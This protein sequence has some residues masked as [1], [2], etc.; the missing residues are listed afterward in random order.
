MVALAAEL[1][2]DFETPGCMNL[3]SKDCGFRGGGF[4]FWWVDPSGGW[5][6]GRLRGYSLETVWV[7]QESD[8]ENVSAL[9]EESL[10]AAVVN[11]LGGH[12]TDA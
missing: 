2:N 5:Q 1:V 6:P 10:R 11:A 9:L 12:E 8:V 4:L 7:G 3:V